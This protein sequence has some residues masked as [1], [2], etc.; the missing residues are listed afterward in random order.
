MP[1]TFQ[2]LVDRAAGLGIPFPVSSSMSREQLEA[3]IA[4]A[5]GTGSPLGVIG[6]GTAPVYRRR[7]RK[8]GGGIVP[9]SPPDTL[10]PQQAAARWAAA[11]KK[12]NKRPVIDDPSADPGLASSDAYAFNPFAGM[13]PGQGFGGSLDDLPPGDLQAIIAAFGPDALMDVVGEGGVTIKVLRPDVEAAVGILI[14]RE[15]NAATVAA[16][17][18]AGAASDYRADADTEIAQITGLSAQDVARIRA[19]AEGEVAAAGNLSAETIAG[20]QQEAA[21]G[22]A[23][24]SL[25][26]QKY[27]ADVQAAIARQ[28]GLDAAAVATI[29]TGAQ[30]R[31]ATTQA[32]AQTGIAAINASVARELGL[33]SGLDARFIAQAQAQADIEVAAKTGLSAQMVA[34][35]NGGAAQEVARQTGLSQQAIANIQAASQEALARLTGTDAR[36]IAQVQGQA[37]VAAAQAAANPFG[38]TADQF[39]GQQ[40]RQRAGDLART[41]A[42][43]NPFRLSTEQF[44]SEQAA[45]RQG[46]MGRT[47]AQYNPFEQGRQDIYDLQT[48]VARGGLTPEQRLLEIEA[49]QQGQNFGNMLNFLGN[50]SAVGTAVGLGAV[51]PFGAGGQVIPFGVSP[52]QGQVGQALGGSLPSLANLRDES[53]EELLFRFGGAAARGITP[54]R[55]RRSF[56]SV[57][58]FGVR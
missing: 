19:Q 43:F 1:V 14:G 34:A 9:I 48:A 39:L 2:G 40:E 49:A 5:R 24:K 16:A 12:F 52:S 37:T 47:R 45:E 50:P 4:R 54:S 8:V 27:V 31:I 21:L 10:N 29:E 44:L 22:V 15:K 11:H 23:E 32:Q 13:V 46:A 33:A 20:L 38:L 7:K 30:E 57:T 41:Q 26:G 17:G 56:R 42:Q 51:Q 18:V 3:A 36:F 35:I 53:E 55:L 25:I 28:T 58:P 6:G